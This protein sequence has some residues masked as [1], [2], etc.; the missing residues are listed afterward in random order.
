MLRK[1]HA[2]SGKTVDIRR[3]C[4]GMP[5][6][7]KVSVTHVVREDQHDIRQFG[8]MNACQISS[9]DTNAYDRAEHT[10][11]TMWSSFHTNRSLVSGVC[12]QVAWVI[13]P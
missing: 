7:A 11:A 12:Q 5:V 3:L 10:Q 8:R 13:K 6:T 4:R 1:Q 2:F 9:S